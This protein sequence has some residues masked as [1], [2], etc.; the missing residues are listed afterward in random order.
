MS[1][2]GNSTLT[3]SPLHLIAVVITDTGSGGELITGSGSVWVVSGSTVSMV[4]SS[5]FGKHVEIQELGPLR[6]DSRQ[7]CVAS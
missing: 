4:M 5:P 2:G 7:P 6:L 1:V 3:G